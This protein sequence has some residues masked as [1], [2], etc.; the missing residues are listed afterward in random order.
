MAAFRVIGQRLP[1]F[2]D[3]RFLT[4]QGRYLDDLQMPRALTAHFLRSP[5]AHARILSI[6]TGPA[7]AL[8]GVRAV[9]T[10]VEIN[11]FVQPLRMAP[12]IDGVKPTTIAAMP[13]DKVR[14][15]GDP[16]ACILAEDRYIAEDAAELITVEYEPLEAVA[17][18][19]T[20]LAQGA[21]RVD[22]TLDSNLVSHQSFAT[23]GIARAF[24]QADRIV[25][26]RFH[27]ARL[28]H[29][30]VETRGCIAI[31]DAGREH[32]TMHVGTQVPASSPAA[33]VP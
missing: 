25:E 17:S 2:E 26:R 14:F 6:D 30:P 18:F 19:E 3:R 16:V 24:A 21:A 13:T 33:S 31:W 27:Q 32:L 20:A 7:L 23:A 29:A 10:G 8:A 5:H 12:A 22:D 11:E 4:G 28:T 9:Y 1:R 15:Q